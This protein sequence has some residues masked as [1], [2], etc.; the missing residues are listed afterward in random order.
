MPE[1][2]GSG[3]GTADRMH[4][5]FDF[6]LNPQIMLALAR[7]A[8]EPLLEGL[9]SA[10][11]VPTGGQWATF[12][13]NHDELDLSRLTVAQREEVFAAFGPQARMQLYGRGLRRRLAPMLGN[14]RRRLELAYALQFSLPGTPVLRYGE[15]IGMGDDLSLPG[16][17]AFRTPMQWD[18]SRNGGFSTAPAGQLVRPAVS[19]GEFG[20][21]AVN[22]SRQR[23]DRD[24]LL[25]WFSRTISV[26]RECP[27]LGRGRA[28]AV[29]VALPPG[30]LA[31][32]VD[33]AAGSLLFL[34]NLADEPV[35]VDLSAMD[36]VHV[37]EEMLSDGSGPPADAAPAE[38][39]LAGYG[40]R[41]MR[42]GAPGRRPRAVA[43][44]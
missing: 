31:H 4:L 11:T 13:R 16:R 6:V 22:V 10:P 43:A 28:A 2:F 8:A 44:R 40:Y 37:V 34:H 26:R 5:L 17:D 39:S 41:W 25:T 15:E 24:S 7:G 1:Y 29:D 14:D 42:L 3:N 23:G 18:G 9:R 32:R 35:T 20:F 36:G 19:R 12:L 33:D 30:V 38:V 21:R 27:E